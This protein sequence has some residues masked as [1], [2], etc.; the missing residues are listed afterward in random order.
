V[1]TGTIAVPR[2]RTITFWV[3]MVV[4]LFLHLGERPQMLTWL[5]TS[6]GGGHDG[7]EIHT[8][9]QGVI[10]WTVIAAVA[11][12]LRATARQ[13]GAA[14]VYGLISVLA[15]AMFLALA[16]LPPEVV[17]IVA[18]VLVVGLVAFLAHPSSLRAKFRPVEPPSR[19]LLG[20][21]AVAAVPL[22]VYAAGQLSIHAGSGPHDEHYQFGHW[23]VM[24]VYALTVIPIGLVAAFKV[25]GW[26]FPAW[27]A[28]AVV[29]LLGVAS[30]GINAVSQLSTPWALA[31]ITWAVAFVG[32]AEREARRPAVAEADARTPART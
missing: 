22:V 5:V 29:G 3:L 17:P 19:S 30:L 15:F 4:L 9:A 24:A 21:I 20:L 14:W 28:G 6:F 7:H 13:V 2:W 11:M 23:I 25:P 1:S 10:G 31:A 18:A 27:V 26:R 16:D 8:F 12:N 32:V